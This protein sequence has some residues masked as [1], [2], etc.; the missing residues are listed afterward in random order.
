MLPPSSRSNALLV[1]QRNR[2]IFAKAFE[3]LVCRQYLTT[4]ATSRRADQKISIRSL[5]AIATTDVKV[6]CR[7]FMVFHIQLDIRKSTKIAFQL[8]ELFSVAN[9]RKHLLSNDTK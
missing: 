6:I 8:F 2:K 7:Q 5:I 9:T 3:I 1:H 4:S